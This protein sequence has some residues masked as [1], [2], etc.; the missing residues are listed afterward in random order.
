MNVIL[1]PMTVLLT[2]FAMLCGVSLS[3]DLIAITMVVENSKYIQSGD[4]SESERQVWR[5]RDV[6]GW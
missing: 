2:P 1:K 6:G 3:I 5:T 4:W